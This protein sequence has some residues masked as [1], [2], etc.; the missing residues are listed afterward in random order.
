MFCG[1]MEKLLYVYLILPINVSV[2]YQLYINYL[3]KCWLMALLQE[4][5]GTDYLM[6]KTFIAYIVSP[7]SKS[8]F[9]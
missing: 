6:T 4:Y 9:V 1:I 8:L 3:N 5:D 2:K 7:Y